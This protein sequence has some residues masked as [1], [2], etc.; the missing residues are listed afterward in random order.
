MI[1]T[2]CKRIGTISSIT[3]VCW[4]AKECSLFTKL[5]SKVELISSPSAGILSDEFLPQ[6]FWDPNLHFDFKRHDYVCM[7]LLSCLPV[8]SYD[9]KRIWFCEIFNTSDTVSFNDHRLGS[10]YLYGLLQYLYSVGNF[11]ILD[12]VIFSS[13]PHSNV[14]PGEWC[15]FWLTINYQNSFRCLSIIF[16]HPGKDEVKWHHNWTNQKG[17]TIAFDNN[18]FRVPSNSK[19]L[20]AYH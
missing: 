19:Q 18:K 8:D 5:K 13:W 14:T 10:Y 1:N 15:K 9:L 11:E 2:I 4:S 3:T 16:L 17:N 20:I 6:P 7:P 12:W